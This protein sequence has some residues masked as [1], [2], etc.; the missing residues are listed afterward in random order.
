[1]KKRLL[2]LIAA[3]VSFAPAVFGATSS[4][5]GAHTS[6]DQYDFTST[7][8]SRMQRANGGATRKASAVEKG[9][10]GGAGAATVKAAAPTKTPPV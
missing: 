3:G 9:K 7:Q 1:M 6:M 8:C 2:I 10:A 5:I 4:R